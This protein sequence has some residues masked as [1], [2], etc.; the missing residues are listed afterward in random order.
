MLEKH[1]TN[2]YS[3]ILSFL[4]FSVI[5]LNNHR[6]SK[7]LHFKKSFT[8]KL[9]RSGSTVILKRYT[10]VTIDPR[11]VLLEL[12]FGLN[13]FLQTLVYQIMELVTER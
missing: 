3:S 2:F 5:Q 10:N 11:L 9:R 12:L 1:L 6:L 8:D 4:M 13:Y 7:L